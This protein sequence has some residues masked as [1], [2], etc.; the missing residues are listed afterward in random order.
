MHFFGKDHL[1]RHLYHPLWQSFYL[2]ILVLFMTLTLS[3]GIWWAWQKYFVPAQFA[4]LLPG[5]ETVLVAQ[6]DQN[7]LLPQS[8]AFKKFLSSHPELQLNKLIPSF[9][10]LSEEHALDLET[11]LQSWLG[12]RALLVVLQNDS[13]FTPL[14][15]LQIDDRNLLEKKLEQFAET[16]IEKLLDG[17]V[18]GL[19]LGSQEVFVRICQ[20]YLALSFEQESL[21]KLLPVTSVSLASDPNWNKLQDKSSGAA[22]QF[23]LKNGAVY[24][25]LT[26]TEHLSKTNKL[27]ISYLDA[28]GPSL[29]RV[30]FADDTL[31]LQSK[32]LSSVAL[33]TV[34]QDFTPNLLTFVHNNDQSFLSGMNLGEKLKTLM[35]NLTSQ[36]I[37]L[38]VPL[39]VLNE[40]WE[41]RFNLN[42]NE[43]LLP[44]LTGE[45]LW[46]KGQNPNESRLILKL[47]NSEQSALL[48]KLKSLIQNYQP[49][50]KTSLA[51]RSLPDGT[52]YQEVVTGKSSPLELKELQIGKYSAFTYQAGSS[53]L[54]LYYYQTP[55]TLI[56]ASD[57]AG[58]HNFLD[59][60]A[61][62]LNLPSIS[63]P[64]GELSL[65]RLSALLSEQNEYVPSKLKTILTSLDYS[66]LL[67]EQKSDWEK[68]SNT[69]TFFKRTS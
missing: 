50:F 7:P 22:L 63:L 31:R 42:L 60:N 49:Y 11:D 47:T 43:D 69:F 34:S 55:Q 20:S 35:L 57:I 1:E 56:L 8:H 66:D 36:K 32:T 25:Y 33:N 53:E 48:E 37:A 45:Y 3:L 30:S 52:S 41:K 23:Y 54:A 15:L 14:L 16:E 58:L 44:L 51:T 65:F 46:I 68:I 64:T 5:K 67:V 27:F 40:Q 29:I 19:K 2:I 24:R 9:Q 26:E 10:V 39:Q 38:G 18:I 17:E 13:Q 21:S 61:S 62:T 4:E 6:L 28:L 12:Y 59:E